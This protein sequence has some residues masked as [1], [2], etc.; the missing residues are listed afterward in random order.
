[1]DLELNRVYLVDHRRKGKFKMQVHKT[2]PDGRGS[3][4]VEGV[5][6]DGVA[7]AKMQY[8]VRLPGEAITVCQSFC[9]WKLLDHESGL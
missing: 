2:A 8:N 9:T 3:N 4:W 6:V 5:I 7:Y 1:M